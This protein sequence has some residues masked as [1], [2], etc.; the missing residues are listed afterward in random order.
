[1]V[2]IHELLARVVRQRADVDVIAHLPPPAGTGATG[3]HGV[4]LILERNADQ[5]VDRRKLHRP[6]R[7]PTRS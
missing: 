4:E 3:E 7:H 6:A 2:E 1:M 5:Q